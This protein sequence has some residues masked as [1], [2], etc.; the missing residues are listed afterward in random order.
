M[1]HVAEEIKS[2]CG[3]ASMTNEDFL[4]HYGTKRHSGRYPWGSG[5]D[6]YQHNSRDFLG[7][8]EELKK[9]GWTETPE[10][11]KNEINELAKYKILTKADDE[12]DKVLAFVKSKMQ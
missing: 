7:R 12:D 8:I 1:N 3:S 2:Y 10:N 9:S 6:P 5:D 11:I 4:E